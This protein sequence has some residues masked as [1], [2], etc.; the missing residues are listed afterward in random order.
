[1]ESVESSA[2]AAVVAPI[3]ETARL[4]EEGQVATS[5]DPAL[6]LRLSYA[7]RLNKEKRFDD[8]SEALSDLLK[9]W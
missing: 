6:R 5:L 8:A 2:I 7:E 4:T 3:E 9:E 1:M